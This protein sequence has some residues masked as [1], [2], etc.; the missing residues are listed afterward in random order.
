[1][2]SQELCQRRFAGSDRSLESYIRLIHGRQAIPAPVSR[3]VPAKPWRDASRCRGSRLG[4]LLNFMGDFT[5]IYSSPVAYLP[6]ARLSE[7]ARQPI[8]PS[9]VISFQ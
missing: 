8:L 2:Q 1:M 3:A 9:A 5:R 6:S 7:L 4:E